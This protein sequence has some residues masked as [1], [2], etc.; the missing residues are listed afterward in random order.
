LGVVYA[1]LPV[2]AIGSPACA[3]PAMAKDECNAGTF[4]AEQ[5]QVP[6]RQ[7]MGVKIASTSLSE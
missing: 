3:L 1:V 6:R 5:S 4:S 7:V 2:N